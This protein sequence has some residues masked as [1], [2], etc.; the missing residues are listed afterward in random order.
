[1]IPSLKQNK[2]QELNCTG[3]I[4]ILLEEVIIELP[5]D[6][7]ERLEKFIFVFQN[8]SCSLWE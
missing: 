2:S 8:S 5:S 7:L 6:K 1:M 4:E 3:W